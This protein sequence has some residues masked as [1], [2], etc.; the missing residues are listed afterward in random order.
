MTHARKD[1]FKN[2]DSEGP[3]ISIPAN[4]PN[5]N[6][7]KQTL[8]AAEDVRNF[9]FPLRLEE[10][11]ALLLSRR[12][13]LALDLS[14]ECTPKTDGLRMTAPVMAS[15]WTGSRKLAFRLRSGSFLAT[16]KS[17][18]HNGTIFQITIWCCVGVP[19]TQVFSENGICCREPWILRDHPEQDP[20]RRRGPNPNGCQVVSLSVPLGGDVPDNWVLAPRTYRANKCFGKC[21]F[22]NMLSLNSTG[23]SKLLYLSS[24]YRSS[25]NYKVCCVPISYESQS[26]IYVDN[27]GHV[28]LKNF[29]NMRVSACGC[30]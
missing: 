3:V 6:N 20:V 5:A 9:V 28:V 29:A 27:Y 13:K 15:G 7:A 22:P 30:R 17:P 8:S 1:T 12:T 16:L 26:L 23:H 2:C 19:V 25:I 14:E 18:L 11:R 24:L 21:L 10:V 4:K